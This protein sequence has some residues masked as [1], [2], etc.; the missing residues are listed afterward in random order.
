MNGFN[1]VAH[2]L[3]LAVNVE[4]QRMMDTIE[5]NMLANGIEITTNQNA[6]VDWMSSMKPG[7]SRKV[8]NDI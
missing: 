6:L 4:S 3:S 1:T 7:A 5:L 2:V 8:S